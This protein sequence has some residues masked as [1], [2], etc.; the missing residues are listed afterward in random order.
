[1]L[2]ST[3]LA[4]L[5]SGMFLY[6]SKPEPPPP[7][8]IDCIA[9]QQQLERRIQSDPGVI[10]ALTTEGTDGRSVIESDLRLRNCGIDEEDVANMG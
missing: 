6:L 3:L 2:G 10:D 4:S 8:P 7:T 9:V 1:M 5:V